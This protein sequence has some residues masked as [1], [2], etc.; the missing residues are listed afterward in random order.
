VKERI[1]D[2]V[3]QE[4]NRQVGQQLGLAMMDAIAVRVRNVARADRNRSRRAVPV[5]RCGA[6]ARR[7]G[8]GEAGGADAGGLMDA[9][10]ALDP[11]AVKGI[12]GILGGSVALTLDPPKTRADLARRLFVSA[13]CGV[14]FP[15]PT[16][17]YFGLALVD[18][19]TK[20]PDYESI[21]AVGVLWGIAGW[22]VLGL[23]VRFFTNRR[24]KDILDAARDVKDAAAGKDKQ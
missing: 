17:R 5:V 6:A 13:V 9:T 19:A 16:L 7:R 23:I 1:V 3:S 11:L 4:I 24:D 18:P 20:L 12:A 22:F 15:G 21:L 8:R 10:P 2:P 14:V